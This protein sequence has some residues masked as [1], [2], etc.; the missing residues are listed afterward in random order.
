M[1]PILLIGGYGVVGR[2][3]ARHL[4]ARHPDL[5]LAIGG[6][7]LEKARALGDELG[8][9]L[10]VTIDLNQRDLGL[11]MAE[12]S[13]MGVYVK[14]GGLNAMGFA[15]RHGIPSVSLSS[16]TFELGVDMVH[17]LRAA[18]NAPIVMASHWFSGAVTIPTIL[19]AE[20]FDR[21]DSIDIGAVIDR[22]DV[23]DGDDIGSGPAAAAEFE[24]VLLSCPSTLLR[25]DGGY[26]WVA[27]DRA[28]ARF[29]RPDG[30]EIEGTV[31]VGCDTLSLA[32][33]TGAR[34]VRL[35]ETYGVSASRQAG[36]AACDEVYIRVTGRGRD[37]APLE[38][39]QVI[40]IPRTAGSLTAISQVIIL[41]R[42]L[43]LAGGPPPSPGLYMVEDVVDP[44]HFVDRMT[45]AGVRF[46]NG[47]TI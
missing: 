14:D 26:V 35:L 47:R 32:T 6:R 42:L 44:S 33:A 2:Q 23:T 22:E 1:R 31:S 12:F 4:R 29:R 15:G 24:Q 46:S 38:V 3:V 8:G 30:V 28:Q 11:P 17:G 34:N 27:G 13:A 41:E 21:V 20:R 25:A 40:S 16:A 9:V 19:L 39:G 36:G 10:A 37:A 45:E 18:Q 7:S 43:G 5:P